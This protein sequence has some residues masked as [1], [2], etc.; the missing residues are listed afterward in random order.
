MMSERDWEKMSKANKQLELKKNTVRFIPYGTAKVLP[1]M[2]RAKVV[3]QNQR[4]I[5]R[6]TMVYL[7]EGQTESLLGKQDAEALGILNIVPEVTP[8]TKAPINLAGVVSGN[9]TQVQID[10]KMEKLSKE[11]D[12]LFQGI[13]KAKI[14][15]IHIYTKK[16]REPVAQKQR[17]VARH[18]LEPLK[19]HL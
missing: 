10:K 3:M 11:Y 18:Y 16:G 12:V 4:G 1:V 7:V 17:P 19:Q 8:V 14:D 2:G 9:Q 15:P 5:Q 13:G 6:K